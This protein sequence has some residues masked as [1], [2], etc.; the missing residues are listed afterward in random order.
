MFI[1]IEV[2]TQLTAEEWEIKAIWVRER[3]RFSDEMWVDLEK[4]RREN[5]LPWWVGTGK[6]WQQNQGFMKVKAKRQI[7]RRGLHKQEH[8]QNWPP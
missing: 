1:L 6:G 2:N 8:L 7:R 5:R 4:Q 3:E